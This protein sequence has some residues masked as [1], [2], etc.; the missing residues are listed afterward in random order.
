MKTY[1]A[2]ALI[3][4]A[5]A[6][7]Q[8]Y[9]YNRQLYDAPRY[10]EA[11]PQL[12]DIVEEP[13]YVEPQYYA[14]PVFN[15]NYDRIFDAGEEIYFGTDSES[16]IDGDSDSVNGKNDYFLSESGSSLGLSYAGYTFYSGSDSGTES[17]SHHS[18]S[19]VH[20]YDH[21]YPN[22]AKVHGNV[23]KDYTKNKN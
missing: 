7:Q 11:E 4:A 14:K 17:S 10:Y 1:F 15:F 19:T 6:V 2:S 9:Y 18:A 21:F 13:Y 12:I 3:V 22:G 16:D 8:D 5:K 20:S 23:T